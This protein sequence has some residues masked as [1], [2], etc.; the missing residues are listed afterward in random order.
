MRWSKHL[1][2]IR[3]QMYGLY[4]RGVTGKELILAKLIHIG[5]VHIG[6]RSSDK[7]LQRLLKASK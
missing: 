7:T 6:S 2:R 1:R 4:K 5:P 3:L